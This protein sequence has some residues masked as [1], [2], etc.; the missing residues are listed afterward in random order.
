MK[1]MEFIRVH[2]VLENKRVA[3]M[4]DTILKAK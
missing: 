1:G 3:V 4:T 2:D